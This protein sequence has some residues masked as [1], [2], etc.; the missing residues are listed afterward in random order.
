M[1]DICFLL[2]SSLSSMDAGKTLRKQSVSL[3]AGLERPHEVLANREAHYE[4]KDKNLSFHFSPPNAS[5]V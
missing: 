2:L 5:E 1:I 4:H 3:F